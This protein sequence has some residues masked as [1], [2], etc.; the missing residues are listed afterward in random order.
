MSTG[1]IRKPNQKVVEAELA[2]RMLRVLESQRL[3]G[4]DAYP[5][6]LGR[7]AELS[8]AKASD[9]LVIQI[10]RR[11]PFRSRALVAWSKDRKPDRDS[12]AFLAGSEDL[13]EIVEEIAPALLLAL[14]KR[15]RRSKTRAFTAARLKDQVTSRLKKPFK[16][17][18]D[19]G[20]EERSLPEEIGWIRAERSTLLFLISSVESSAGSISIEANGQADPT[21]TSH[22]GQPLTGKT[23]PAPQP[24]WE[25]APIPDSVA[26]EP[27][28][29]D[30][31]SVFREAF[32]R[33]DRQNG[34]T[35]FVR[36]LDLRQAL[37]EFDRD[38]FDEGLRRLRLNDEFTLDSHEVRHRPL[39]EQEREAGIQEAGTL[40]VYVSRRS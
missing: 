10:P 20:I 11:E 38:R 1:Q 15:P 36:L 13:N 17:A 4:G 22:V 8:G 33:L 2:D 9:P 31:A 19:R 25:T 40:L 27:D 23:P 35:N 3:L 37:S 34:S 32:D 30:F 5:P 18:I 26:P 7:L 12:P 21:S 16:D 39:T 29:H 14:L 24:A 28:A 6:T